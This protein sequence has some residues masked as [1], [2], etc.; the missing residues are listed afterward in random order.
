MILIPSSSIDE[1]NYGYCIAGLSRT[2]TILNHQFSWL[3]WCFHFSQNA[4]LTPESYL[5][6]ISFV[7]SSRTCYQAFS[8]P[9]K[10]S[11]NLIPL[12]LL[13]NEAYTFEH[14][15]AVSLLFLCL[16][17]G[18]ELH[19]SCSCIVLLPLS[20]RIFSFILLL[21][22]FSDPLFFW[23]TSLYLELWNHLA[24]CCF[25]AEESLLEV[26]GYSLLFLC[27]SFLLLNCYHHTDWSS[28][29]LKL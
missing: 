2:W 6:H 12:E 29:K 14:T 20:P 13:N 4:C 23:L 8:F 7:D 22:P 21:A 1:Y 26:L 15:K 18:P 16:D 5:L 25:P 27:A 28:K 9:T 24:G 10:H 17:W 3:F 11:K 19:E